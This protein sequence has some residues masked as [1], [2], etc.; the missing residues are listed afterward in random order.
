MSRKPSL[1]T[2][3]L[4]PVLGN[5]KV[6]DALRADQGDPSLTADGLLGRVLAIA[7]APGFSKGGYTWGLDV[8]PKN[9]PI[10]IRTAYP[11]I[12]LSKDGFVLPWPWDGA[13]GPLKN[14]R[15]TAFFGHA[16]TIGGTLTTTGGLRLSAFMHAADDAVTTKWLSFREWNKIV[17]NDPKD[18][19]VNRAMSEY[20]YP[21][22]P[23]YPADLVVTPDPS[24]LPT[25]TAWEINRTSGQ[26]TLKL[27]TMGL[28]TTNIKIDTPPLF[29][30]WPCGAFV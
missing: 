3:L 2:V 17:G 13:A 15:H 9:F 23:D 10:R 21:T 19:I 12:F 25:A 7:R 14:R 16:D 18:W 8:W 29:D 20:G 26:M 28:P 22:P 27:G 4:D 11:D 24:R 30:Y 1:H 6:R 5:D